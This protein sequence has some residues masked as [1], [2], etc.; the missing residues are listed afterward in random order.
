MDN[1]MKEMHVSVKVTD[2]I[3]F[4]DP[5]PTGMTTCCVLL[6]RENYPD[7][8]EE[9]RFWEGWSSTTKYVHS[10]Y[11]EMGGT[12]GGQEEQESLSTCFCHS[13]STWDFGRHSDQTT[14]IKTL[15]HPCATSSCPPILHRLWWQ[16]KKMLILLSGGKIARVIS[17]KYEDVWKTQ[18]NALLGKDLP[19]FDFVRRTSRKNRPY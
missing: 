4:T 17:A 1:D 7:A 16:I 8:S 19:W 6:L 10:C 9:E 13:D 2:S 15:T 14:A 5:C 12:G 11:P 3:L 18:S